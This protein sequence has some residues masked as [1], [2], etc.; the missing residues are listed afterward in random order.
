M[1]EWKLSQSTEMSM[2]SLALSERPMRRERVEWS[3]STI[4]TGTLS[5]NPSCMRL[6][7]KNAHPSGTITI[8]KM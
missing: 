1:A 8:M 5:G 3:M 4:A 6:R 7:K 2:S